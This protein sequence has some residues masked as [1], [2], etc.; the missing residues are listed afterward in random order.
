MKHIFLSPHFD[1][2]AL[3]CGGLIWDL[4]QSGVELEVWTIC[5]GLPPSQQLSDFAASMHARWRL[6]VEQAV[7]ARREEDAAAMARLDAPSRY[8]AVPDAIYRRHP[9]TGE[10]LYTSDEELFGGLGPGDA[11]FVRLLAGTLAEALPGGE[12]RLIAPLTVGNHVDHQLVRAA[13][14]QLSVSVAY[15]PDYPYSR[16]HSG[17]EIAALAPA[18]YRPQAYPVSADGLAAWQDSSAAYASQISTFWASEAALREEIAAH[19]ARFQGVTLWE[20]GRR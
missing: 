2:A 13:A 12:A 11:A 15:Y 4:A 8:F 1:D 9:K 6:S 16:E 7:Q 14:E 18:G 20:M 5:A 17:G 10:F 19:S 3:S